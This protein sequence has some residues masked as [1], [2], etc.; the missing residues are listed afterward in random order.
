MKEPLGETLV[1][2]KG[3]SQVIL[4]ISSLI[5]TETPI[6]SLASFKVIRGNVLMRET[7]KEI[8]ASTFN[9]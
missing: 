3:A 2:I 4:L 9:Y 1:I 7:N 8:I 6:T 5:P